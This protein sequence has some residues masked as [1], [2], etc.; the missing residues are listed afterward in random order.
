MSR[1]SPLNFQHV[2]I[3]KLIHQ[4]VKLWG[5]QANQNP[6][7]FKSPTGSGKTFMV[8]QFINK[9]NTLPNWS[10]DKAFVWITFNDELAMQSKDKFSAY[11]RGNL[12]NNLLTINDFQQG[13]L[14][15]NDIL[16]INWQKLVSRAAENR[17]LRRPTDADLR[18]EQGYYFEEIVENTVKDGRTL[19]L[20]VD[21]SHTHLSPLAQE[22]V[23]NVIDPKVI[24]YVSATPKYIPNAAEI[25]SGQAGYVSVRREDVVSEGL[26]KEKIVTQTE[27]DLQHFKGKDFDEVL[28]DLAIAKKA[29]LE[30]E[31]IK[32]NKEIN[33]LVLIQLPND[34]NR[35]KEIDQKSKE[36]VVLNY[37]KTKG[38]NIETN[39]ALWFD[40]KQKNLDCITNNESEVDF[41]LFKQ[42]AGTGWDCPRAHILVMF[43]EI[44]SATFYTQTLG[45]ILRMPEPNNRQD[46]KDSPI[47]RAGF[48]YTNYKRNEIGIPDQSPTN[49]PFVYTSAIRAGISNIKNLKSGYISRIDY[50]DLGN[51]FEFQKSFVKSL[52]HY[53]NIAAHDLLATT[54]DK[55]AAKKVD[56]NS[57][58]T[59]SL[60]ADAEFVVFD[61]LKNVINKQGRTSGFVVSQND[62]EKLFN[63]FCY[64][65]LAEQ[66]ENEAK[67]SNTSRS[68][69]PLKSA[70]RVWFKRNLDLNS[71]YYYRIF[72]K[73]V[74]REQSSVFRPAI[75]QAL[76]EYRPVLSRLIAERGQREENKE[77]PSFFIRPAYSFTEDFSV[78]TDSETT[79]TLCAIQP[80]YIRKEYPGRLNEIAF[81]KY[82]EQQE[83]LIEWWFKNGDSGK[84]YFS[85]N[86][87]NNADAKYS[88]FY[89][90]W[91]VKFRNGKI[92]FFDTK[93]GLSAQH[94]E[95][96]AAGL[97]KKIELLNSEE[98]KYMGGIVLLENNQWYINQS[99][100]YAY[101]PGELGHNWQP[102]EVVIKQVNETIYN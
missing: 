78:L 98:Q 101:T 44:N 61:S 88:L 18:K 56:L 49:K 99:I 62:V 72:I 81:I 87:F 46:Y 93:S 83:D 37:I 36:E 3:D 28:L 71:D 54:R 94:T 90:D 48:L 86:Y 73:D 75:T 66:T 8:A 33:P 55:I 9:L 58:L 5:N 1:F 100:N 2:A 24:V 51:S 69:S 63:F 21:E 30:Q 23:V 92:G 85:V 43:R 91:L 57:E 95:G 12:E 31:Y 80:F 60:I 70:L 6:L 97:A 38:F 29:E 22:K 96:R 74:L 77:A 45:R 34:D 59:E 67:V 15:K 4:F 17:V 13:K 20:I 40:G 7:V 89:P 82:L 32:L 41:L 79:T 25:E 52:N 68:W 47:L 35:L 26:I 11:F 53:F 76:K 19:V 64:K 16:F 84:D 65:L 27:E 10:A 39:V 42:A 50:G 102:L 14:E